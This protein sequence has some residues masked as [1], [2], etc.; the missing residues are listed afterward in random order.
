MAKR[1]GNNEGT[2]LQMPNGKWRV[3]FTLQGHR[4]SFT[5]KSRQACLDWIRHTQNQIDDGLNYASAKVKLG[6][7]LDDWLVAE[8]GAMRPSTW[9]HYS[10]LCRMYIAPNIGNIILKDLKTAHLRVLYVRLQDQDVGIPTVM[11]IHKLMHSAL[12]AAVDDGIIIRNPVSSA[13]PPKE[14]EVK[15]K[16]LSEDQASQFLAAVDGHRWVAL[17]HLALATGMRRSELLGLRWENL[18]WIEHTIRIEWQLSKSPNSSA[19]FQPLKTKSSKRTVPIGEQI[20]Q[21]LRDH[22]ERQRLMRIA[23][24]NKW[25]DYDL[26][27]TNEIGGPICA[28][29]MI[30]VFKRLLPPGLPRIRFHDCRHSAASIM[31]NNG[32]PAT[33]VASILGHSKI[34][35][36]FDTYSHS[37]DS[38]QRNAAT[39]IDNLITPIKLH[40]NCTQL[41]PVGQNAT[42]IDEVLPYMAENLNISPK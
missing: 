41:H 4:L 32:I 6:R 39:L 30:Q 27:F 11:K 29:Y 2:I 28:S 31:I 7:Y 34:S 8:K 37:T 1:R 40:S 36:T 38:Q 26:I 18:D 10:Q 12:R 35:M 19:M 16:I 9:S 24:G 33:A 5:A 22:Y 20:I 15:R 14:S 23:A 13:H 42:E 25:I 21:V 17:F 3:Q